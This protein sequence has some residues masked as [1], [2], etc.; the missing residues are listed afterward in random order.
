MRFS[1]S[2]G[3]HELM[4][5]KVL[6]GDLAEFG[7][8]EIVITQY[9]NLCSCFFLICTQADDERVSDFQF[10]FSMSMGQIKGQ[11]C[12]SFACRGAL[13]GNKA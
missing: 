1:C 8:C 9:M 4:C 7:K 10:C 5:V 12:N 13:L 2:L 6:V 3:Q 11:D